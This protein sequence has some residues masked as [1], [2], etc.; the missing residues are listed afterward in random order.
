MHVEKMRSIGAVREIQVKTTVRC[1]TTN[2]MT[3][4]KNSVN[5][6]RKNGS[7]DKLL[8]EKV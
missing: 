8:A 1:Y 6:G 5:E 3:I 4:V 7:V 2:K